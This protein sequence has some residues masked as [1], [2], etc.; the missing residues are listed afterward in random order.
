M[1]VLRVNVEDCKLCG[2]PLVGRL[3]PLHEIHIKVEPPYDRHRCCCCTLHVS[4]K[5]TSPTR[6]RLMCALCCTWYRC[7]SIVAASKAWAGT[8]E[9]RSYA[10]HFWTI[11]F[12]MVFVFFFGTSDE[13]YIPVYRHVPCRTPAVKLSIVGYR[14]LPTP[15]LHAWFTPHVS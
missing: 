3:L 6:Q 1:V 5:D 9:S 15:T 7:P 11:S 8:I 10:K 4:L 13:G 2:V 12:L 14:R